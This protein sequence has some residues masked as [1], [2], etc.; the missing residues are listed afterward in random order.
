M[1]SP[2]NFS[3][4]RAISIIKK[5]L[6]LRCTDLSA[7]YNLLQKNIFF[8]CKPDAEQIFWMYIKRTA[9]KNSIFRIFLRKKLEKTL[10]VKYFIKINRIPGPNCFV[11]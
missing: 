11:A 1:P 6:Y 9:I 10:F 8:N 3:C 5:L 7:G 2:P 4:S